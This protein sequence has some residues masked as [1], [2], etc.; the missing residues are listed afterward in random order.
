MHS[1]LDP[2]ECLEVAKP[3][4]RLADLLGVIPTDSLGLDRLVELAARM[5][6]TA[7]QGVVMPEDVN[8]VTDHDANVNVRGEPLACT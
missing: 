5:G 6:H 8:K 1:R 2:I 4:H 7:D 3:F